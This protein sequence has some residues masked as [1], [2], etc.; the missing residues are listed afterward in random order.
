MPR[1]N[2]SA[3]PADPQPLAP[4]APP[5]LAAVPSSAPVKGIEA[6]AAKGVQRRFATNTLLIQE[7]DVGNTLY[8]VMSG[9]LRVFAADERG[10]EVTLSVVGPG[11]Y[12]GE[13]TLDGGLR[14]ACVQTLA[15]TVCSVV[16]RDILRAHIANDPDF[17]FEMM[18]RLIRR[19]R[20]A[21]ESVRSLALIDTYGRLAR[22]LDQMAV[23]HAEGT[24]IVAER[25]THQ[26]LANHVACSREMVSRLLKDLET[27]GYLR[28][29]ERKL[30]LMKPLPARW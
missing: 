6:L 24:R 16:T 19:A 5:S 4:G 23:P 7:G 1:K 26:D 15:A 20:L 12:V 2:K 25:V 14:S 30:V 9:R 13:M 11:D 8:V 21:T 27:G 17:A 10:K 3:P 22:L 29:V 28:V 18:S